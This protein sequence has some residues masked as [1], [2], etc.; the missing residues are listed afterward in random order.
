MADKC[1]HLHPM[2][3]PP[4]TNPPWYIVGSLEEMNVSCMFLKDSLNLPVTKGHFVIIDKNSVDVPWLQRDATTLSCYDS[5][6]LICRPLS[7]LVGRIANGNSVRQGMTWMEFFLPLKEFIPQNVNSCMSINSSP[8]ASMKELI[9]TPFVGYVKNSDVCDLAFVF[10]Q[11]FLETATHAVAAGMDNVFVCR[12]IY[13]DKNRIHEDMPPFASFVITD[14][15]DNPFPKHVWDGIIVIQELC[16]SVLSTYSTKQGDYFVSSKK[17]NFA[18]DVWRYL[19]VLRFHGRARQDLVAR[20]TI[21]HQRL[22]DGVVARSVRDIRHSVQYHFATEQELRGVFGRTT[23]FG[24]CC[25]HP[26]VGNMKYLQHLDIINVV[27]PSS[28]EAIRDGRGNGI[29]LRFDGKDL[30]LKIHYHKYIYKSTNR[31][32]CPCPILNAAIA[33]SATVAAANHNASVLQLDSLFCVDDMILEITAVGPDHIEAAIISPSLRIG[34]ILQYDREFVTQR[35][36][37]Y[38][39]IL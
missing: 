21:I 25:H 37:K 5:E 20:R 16:R 11:I 12:Y 7:Y 22:D 36:R 33:Y 29:M 8:C 10:S 2:V 3:F 23:T 27:V 6:I 28:L 15:F 18:A 19:S 32:L 26:K 38:T 34:E 13:H 1:Y 9:K 24:R 4:T 31:T 35:V 17:V 30:V 39:R 14:L